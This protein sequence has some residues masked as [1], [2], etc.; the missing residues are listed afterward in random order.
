M[1][2]PSQGALQGV[3][4]PGGLAAF[5]ERGLSSSMGPAGPSAYQQPATAMTPSASLPVQYS[6]GGSPRGYSAAQTTAPADT[7]HQA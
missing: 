4:Q 3:M 5:Q 2:V 1:Q 6:Q 7:L